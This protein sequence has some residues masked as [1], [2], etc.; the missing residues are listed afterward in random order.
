M[1]LGIPGQFDHPA[2]LTSLDKII[3]AAKKHDKALGRLVPTTDQGISQYK[4]GFGM[5]CYSGDIWVLRDALAA[6][7]KT[8][9]AGCA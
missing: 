7:V 3:A 9:R 4:K 8:L 6:A 1:S 5:C 2:F